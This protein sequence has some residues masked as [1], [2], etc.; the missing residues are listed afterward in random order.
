MTPIHEG[1]RTISPAEY[2]T[3]M[4]DTQG[5]RPAAWARSLAG[6]VTLEVLPEEEGIEYANILAEAANDQKEVF[7]DTY[8]AA[9]TKWKESKS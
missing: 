1:N 7:W 9:L 5:D 8:N 4:K 6:L 2:L 3:A